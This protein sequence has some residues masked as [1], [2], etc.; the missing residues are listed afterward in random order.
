MDET[1]VFDIL[2]SHVLSELD[3]S[4]P[5]PYELLVFISESMNNWR[6]IAP[7]LG[8]QAVDREDI[9][10]NGTTAQERRLLM[11]EKW[12]EKLGN[13]ST[14]FNL[15]KGFLDAGRRDLADQV[16]EFFIDKGININYKTSF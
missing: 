14:F 6:D 11:L 10:E 4:I 16:C 7:Y 15:V 12:R 13:T 2:R 9:M 3:M 8:L 1:T 5:V